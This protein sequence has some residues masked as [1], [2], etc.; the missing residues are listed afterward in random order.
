MEKTTVAPTEW[1]S[2]PVTEWTSGPPEPEE[3][4]EE[5]LSHMLLPDSLSQLE[6]F[7]RYKRPRKTHHAHSRPRLFSD[8]WVR[9]GDR[10]G[11]KCTCQKPHYHN[12]IFTAA[13]SLWN[14][15]AK[16]Y[17]SWSVLD[18][19][20]VLIHTFLCWPQHNATSEDQSNKWL[21][22]GGSSSYKTRTSAEK[23]TTRKCSPPPAHRPQCT[24]LSW[25]K[26]EIYADFPF[27][28]LS[29]LTTAF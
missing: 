2:E 11:E 23:K 27:G 13:L 8:L 18:K 29:Y 16:E 1:S 25:S 10:W 6:E 22:D 19:S 15:I 7:G 24:W 5:E 4:S 3:A 17:I 21:C 26:P 20:F 12:R 14:S 9:I 28:L